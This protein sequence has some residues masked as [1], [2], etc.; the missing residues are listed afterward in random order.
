MFVESVT[1]TF[2]YT[3]GFQTSCQLTSAASLTDDITWLPRAGLESVLDQIPAGDPI[4]DTISD[5]TILD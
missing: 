3:G 2:S 4:E 5:P 1:H